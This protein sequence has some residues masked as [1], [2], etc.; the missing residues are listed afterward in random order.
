MEINLNRNVMSTL[1][2]NHL[3]NFLFSATHQERDTHNPVCEPGDKRL[4]FNTQSTL[5]PASSKSATSNH[6]QRD[7]RRHFELQQ[8]QSPSCELTAFRPLDLPSSVGLML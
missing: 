2:K 6:E 4:L 8:L 5:L 3:Q 7:G 1:A